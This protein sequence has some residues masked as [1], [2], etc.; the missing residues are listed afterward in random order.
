VD[1]NRHLYWLLGAVGINRLCSLVPTYHYFDPFPFYNITDQEGHNV[2]IT[3]Q[4]Y[5]WGISN[6][7]VTMALFHL[8]TVF[9]SAKYS[10][11]FGIF[12]L[13]ECASLVDYLLIYEHSLFN[14][15]SY[16]VEFTDIKIILYTYF[17]I[18]WNQQM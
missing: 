18:R 15:W 12:F 4:S 5:I 11:L 8:L 9:A 16:G 10:Q 13:L 14:L 3:L 6:H 17:I 7:V 2:G 1:K